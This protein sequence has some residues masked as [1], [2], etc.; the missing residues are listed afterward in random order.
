MRRVCCCMNRQIDN[1]AKTE[2]QGS[3]ELSWLHTASTISDSL[4]DWP[5]EYGILSK[6]AIVSSRAQ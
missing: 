2:R 1:A 5:V 6:G 4:L 3:A